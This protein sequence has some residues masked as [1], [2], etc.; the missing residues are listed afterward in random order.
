[1]SCEHKEYEAYGED[2]YV[3]DNEEMVEVTKVV[4][5]DCGLTGVIEIVR[6]NAPTWSDP[7]QTKL[8]L[9]VEE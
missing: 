5:L 2:Y 6:P 4:C 7:Y 3:N 1:M 9:I 8:P